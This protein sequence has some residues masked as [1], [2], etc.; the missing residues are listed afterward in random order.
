MNETTTDTIIWHVLQDAFGQATEVW[1]QYGFIFSIHAAQCPMM[2]WV[3]V[4]TYI[5]KHG[6][7][8]RLIVH[9]S[10]STPRLYQ[11]RYR[12]MN[13]FWLLVGRTGV[14]CERVHTGRHPVPKT[15]AILV[16]LIFLHGRKFVFFTILLLLFT[17]FSFVCVSWPRHDN[18]EL[19]P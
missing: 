4:H 19:F 8:I 1:T 7:A 15:I 3:Y 6:Q 13:G 18:P 5:S 17:V 12:W 2:S 14:A 9:R 16:K 10:T 11:Y